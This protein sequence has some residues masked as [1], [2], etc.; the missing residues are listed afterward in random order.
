MAR[1]S[2]CTKEYILKAREYLT[3]WRDQGDAIPSA[4]GLAFY[5]DVAE[6]TIYEHSKKNKEFSEIVRKLNG[7]Q[8]RQLINGG[9]TNELNANIAKLILG[10]HGYHDKQDQ[11]VT[12]VDKPNVSVEFKPVKRKKEPEDTQPVDNTNV[13][14]IK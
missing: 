12:Q 1:P 7:L 2:K 4:V 6:S 13:V 10:K 5:L 11:N 14:S 8:K 9:L 3:N